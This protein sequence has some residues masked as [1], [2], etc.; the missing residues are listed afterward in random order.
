MAYRITKRAGAELPG[1]RLPWQEQTGADTW[2]DL[3]LSSGYTFTLEIETPAGTVV[4][5]KTTGITGGVGYVD[6][7]WA[8]GELDIAKG[9]YLFKLR[10]RETATGKD[11][12]YSPG[13]WPQLVIT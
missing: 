11:R 5:T 10:A 3:D 6:V 12:D 8:T 4:L 1:E 13:G 2:E 9:T 7:V